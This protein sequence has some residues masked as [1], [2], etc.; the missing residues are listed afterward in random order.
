MP[1]ITS[2]DY[3]RHGYLFDSVSKSVVSL[4]RYSKVS[5]SYI[6]FASGFV[7]HVHDTKAVILTSVEAFDEDDEMV[8]VRFEDGTVK[9]ASVFVSNVSSIYTSLV[10]DDI[11]SVKP[12]Q[13]SDASIERGDMIYT[14]ARVW[15]EILEDLGM[16]T[17]SVIHPNCISVDRYSGLRDT[18]YDN[19][20]ALSCPVAGPCPELKRESTI[21]RLIGAPVFNFN[22]DLAGI[23]ERSS[24]RVYDIKF[25]RHSS[26]VID[27]LKGALES[28][29]IKKMAE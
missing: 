11:S 12:V 2:V 9:T 13:F 10:V 21:A 18:R 27:E 16:Y 19:L 8:L 3:A 29:L 5:R 20:F 4:H 25:A 24:N 17:G 15:P 7:L 1:A 26:S 28:Q 22:A 6:D 23:I 14:Y